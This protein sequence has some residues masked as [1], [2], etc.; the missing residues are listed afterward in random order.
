MGV[1][2]LIAPLRNATLDIKS[3]TDP[4]TA[5]VNQLPPLL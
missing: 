2:G 3:N 1:H 4:G 5:G